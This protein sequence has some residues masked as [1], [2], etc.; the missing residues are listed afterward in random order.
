M[1]FEFEFMFE[2]PLNTINVCIFAIRFEI[3]SFVEESTQHFQHQV[4]CGLALHKIAISY[5]LRVN[6]LLTLAPSWGAR[7]TG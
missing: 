1:P 5:T 4:C 3:L 2:F 6:I 7:P